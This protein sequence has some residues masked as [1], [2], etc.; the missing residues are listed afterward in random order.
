[1]D[2]ALEVFSRK[3]YAG[4]TIGA[5][6]KKAG[7]SNLTVFRHFQNKENLF[8]EVV[9]EFSNITVDAAMLDGLVCGKPL[10]EGLTLLS[11][12]YFE[13]LFRNIHI[14]RIF[15]IDATHFPWLK[16]SSWRMPPQLTGY[17][18]GFLAR[19][20]P[21]SPIREKRLP[22][23]TDM[24]LTHITRL[25]LQFNKHDSIWEFSGDLL[26][27]FS[28][29]MKPQ[30]EFFVDAMLAENLDDQVLAP[31]AT[32]AGKPSREKP[33]S[34]QNV[35]RETAGGGAPT[36]KQRIQDAAIDLFTQ[37]G[38]TGTTTNAIAKA[39]GINEA[40]IFRIFSNKKALFYDVYLKM[41][42]MTDDVDLSELTNGE[43][44]GRDMAT[45]L[46]NYLIKHI[47]H[48][49][50]YRLSLQLQD[51]IYERELYYA[52]FD[53]IRGLIAQFVGYLSN[54]CQAGKITERDYV[55]LAEFMFSLLLIKA[56]EYSLAGEG[57]DGE[58]NDMDLVEQFAASY[59]DDLTRVLRPRRA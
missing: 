57:K 12:A 19:A 20:M 16:E 25:A 30:I 24:F 8:R 3:G 48:M 11:Q 22:L 23:L 4:A 28:L 32:G 35:I 49:P 42:P 38:Y 53:K 51:E 41:T 21:D 37:K 43:D 36:N 5:I 9:R 40:A 14:F 13:I 47:S 2:G 31:A 26:S 50:V 45:F 56:Q 10:R 44:L 34:P 27:A 18:R 39:A 17:L 7:V 15:I 52:S 55:A 54:L 58:V 33:D 29:K 59:A 1:M 6:I 46:R